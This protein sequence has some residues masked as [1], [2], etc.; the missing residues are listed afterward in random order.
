MKSYEE[1]SEKK[2]VL[3][4][5]PLG[6]HWHWLRE[7][8]IWIWMTSLKVYPHQEPP[9][10]SCFSDKDNKTGSTTKQSTRDEITVNA[11]I[12]PKS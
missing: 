9:D 4:F 6:W 3:P 12:K 2:Q 8:K 11:V 7:N 5:V 10:D 1:Q